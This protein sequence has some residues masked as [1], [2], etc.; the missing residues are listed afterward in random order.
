M[1]GGTAHFYTP[2]CQFSAHTALHW[3]V[4]NLRAT[5]PVKTNRKFCRLSRVEYTCIGTGET[6]W[7]R[8]YSRATCSRYWITKS[9]ISPATRE[10]NA[11][12]CFYFL[13]RGLVSKWTR[14]IFLFFFR[15]TIT[16][17]KLLNIF[18]PSSRTWGLTS[19]QQT[20][21]D[22]MWLAVWQKHALLGKP[23]RTSSTSPRCPARSS[24]R[25]WTS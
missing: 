18:F 9:T 21:G 14:T 19:I 1:G 4:R 16:L 13:E 11:H 25:C 5:L 3:M 6:H 7:Q 8:V 24:S 12:I 22:F 23:S 15:K 10:L 20:L 2:G 17:Q